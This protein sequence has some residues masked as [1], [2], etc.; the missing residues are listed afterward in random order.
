[1]VLARLGG[2]GSAVITASSASRNAIA[3]ANAA[4]KPAA[5]TRSHGGTP[6]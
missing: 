5:V 2:A 3:V 4:G 1:M 6:P